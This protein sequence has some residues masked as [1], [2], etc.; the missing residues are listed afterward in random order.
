MAP[1]GA[2]AEPPKK[3]AAKA[4]PAKAAAASTDAAASTEKA[5]KAS[6]K[7]AEDM[8]TT[9][10]LAQQLDTKPTTLRRWL[11]SLPAFTDGTYTRYQWKLDD[12]F[13]ED[14]PASFA[15][16]ME[17]EKERNKKRLAELKKKNEAKAAAEGKAPKGAKGKA[18]KAEELDEVEESEEGEELEEE[19]EI[20]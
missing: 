15:K 5:A 3:A 1:K 9:K 18:A 12:P 7:P 8:I 11:R 4:A 20:E 17:G 6:K 13:L 19:S 2:V 14:A 16:F 10:E